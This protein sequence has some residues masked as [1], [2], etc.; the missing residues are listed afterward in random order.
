M[1]RVSEGPLHEG[2][3]YGGAAVGLGVECHPQNLES[4]IAGMEA[5]W[6]MSYTLPVWLESG[7]FLCL[8]P[9]T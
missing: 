5:S 8:S 1:S 2:L 9:G 6:D 4:K 7:I 3:G